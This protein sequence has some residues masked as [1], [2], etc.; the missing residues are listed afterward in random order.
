MIERRMFYL[1]LRSNNNINNNDNKNSLYY[2]DA[3]NV[4]PKLCRTFIHL[5]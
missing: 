4:G 2:R 3:Q 5:K 1:K